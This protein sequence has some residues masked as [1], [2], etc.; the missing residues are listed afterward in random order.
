M[1]GFNS[2]RREFLFRRVPLAIAGVALTTSGCAPVEARAELPKIV[3]LPENVFPLVY[4]TGEEFIVRALSC[5]EQLASLIETRKNDLFVNPNLPALRWFREVNDGYLKPP[6][7]LQVFEIL[8]SDLRNKLVVLKKWDMP[9]GRVGNWTDIFIGT[10]GQPYLEKTH[11]VLNCD[12]V[13]NDRYPSLDSPQ[14]MVPIS[15]LGLTAWVLYEY[16]SRLQDIT[17]MIFLNNSGRFNGIKGLTPEK[18]RA[19][20][21]RANQASFQTGYRRSRDQN[22]LQLAFVRSVAALAGNPSGKV[23]GLESHMDWELYK[24]AANSG[25]LTGD[26]NQ[27]VQMIDYLTVKAAY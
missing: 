15:N 19:E 7:L 24:L 6:T 5:V 9:I 18:V 20:I 27:L 23:V 16:G 17:T 25:C 2:E 26:F 14:K 1:L 8:K 12:G 10:D 4:P 21:E 13:R 22:L 3:K 11:I